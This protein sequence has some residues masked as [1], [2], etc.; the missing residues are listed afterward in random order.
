LGAALPV[1]LVLLLPL[2]LTGAFWSFSEN[3]KDSPKSVENLLAMIQPSPPTA[4]P[5]GVELRAVRS[6]IVTLNDGNQVVDITG[7]VHNGTAFELADVRIE[8]QLY[9]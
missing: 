4:P 9:S 5:A 6:Q 7:S 1:L 2:A 3:L 8:T